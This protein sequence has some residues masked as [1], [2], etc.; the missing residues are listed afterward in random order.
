[1]PTPTSNDGDDDGGGEE[2]PTFYKKRFIYFTY[3]GTL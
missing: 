1:M 3:M 2:I